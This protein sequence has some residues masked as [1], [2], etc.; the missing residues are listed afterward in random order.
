MLEIHAGFRIHLA[1]LDAQ[2]P[3]LLGRFL[4]CSE[5][6]SNRSKFVSLAV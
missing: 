2:D 1:N 6:E 3:P 4:D 5:E